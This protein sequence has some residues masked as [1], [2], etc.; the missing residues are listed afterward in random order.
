MAFHSVLMCHR[1][2]TAPLLVGIQNVFRFFTIVNNTAMNILEIASL[3]MFSLIP[4][5][6][7]VPVFILIDVSNIWGLPFRSPFKRVTN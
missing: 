7:G 3:C 4:E 1:F 5:S 6:D 2:L